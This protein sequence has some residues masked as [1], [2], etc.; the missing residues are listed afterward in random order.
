[1]GATR[2]SQRRRPGAYQQPTPQRSKSDAALTQAALPHQIARGA[3]PV[4]ESITSHT[5][6]EQCS[7]DGLAFQQP[8]PLGHCFDARSPAAKEA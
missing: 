3:S 1:M 7:V 8:E 4:D 6:S 2:K 5:L